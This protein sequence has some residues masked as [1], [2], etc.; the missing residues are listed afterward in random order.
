MRLGAK[1]TQVLS[2]RGRHTV[3]MEK[4]EDKRSGTPGMENSHKEDESL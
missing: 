3:G 2:M 1:Q 4:G